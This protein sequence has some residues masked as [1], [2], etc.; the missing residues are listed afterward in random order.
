MTLKRH[1]SAIKVV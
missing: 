1:R